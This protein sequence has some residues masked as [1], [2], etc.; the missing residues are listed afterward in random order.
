MRPSTAVSLSFVLPLV[1]GSVHA[2][3]SGQNST[4]NSTAYITEFVSALKSSGFDGFADTLT[5]INGTDPA[6]ELFSELASGRNFTVF[7]PDDNASTPPVLIYRLCIANSSFAVQQIPSEISQ[8]TTLLAEYIAYHFIDGDF[9]NS[10]FTNSSGSGGGGGG[11]SSSSSTSS[12]SSTTSSE[13]SATTQSTVALLGR[14]IGIFRRQDGGGSSS[15]LQPLAGIYPNVTI[16]R[17]LFNS[18]DLVSLEGNKSQVLVW[19]RPSP[20]GNITIL[21]QG[22]VF[23]LY[24]A[25]CIG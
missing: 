8:N 23:S 24:S 7:A 21:N 13:S 15:N 2:Q 25:L 5:Q 11:S 10:S 12:E 18:S 20:D 3:D 16:G 14:R 17:S 9:T 6:K 19:S 22:Y 1:L 4:S